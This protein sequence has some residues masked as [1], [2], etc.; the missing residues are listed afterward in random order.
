[1][2]AV[3][4]CRNI[5]SKASFYYDAKGNL[6]QLAQ[7]DATGGTTRISST[8]GFAGNLLTQ[9]QRIVPINMNRAKLIWLCNSLAQVESA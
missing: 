3:V 6:R 9:R 5:S 7:S 1:M 2:R 4:K 8:Y